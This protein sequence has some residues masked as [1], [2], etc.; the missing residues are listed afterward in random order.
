MICGVRML[1]FIEQNTTEV[2][3]KY[4][5]LNLI[6]FAICPKSIVSNWSFSQIVSSFLIFTSCSVISPA[7]SFYSVILK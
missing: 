2:N 1:K 7:Q 3:A 5:L 6:L 4:K